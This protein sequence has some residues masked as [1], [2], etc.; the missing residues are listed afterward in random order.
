M[1][2]L[3][4]LTSLAAAVAAVAAVAASAAPA[5][6]APGANLA[7]VKTYLLEHTTALEGF[8]KNFSVVANRYYAAA[9]KANFDYRALGTQPAVRKDLTRA[10]ALWVAGNPM[11]EQVEGVVAGTPS[12]SVYDVILDAGSSA[13]AIKARVA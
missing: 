13:S 7:P 5:V 9:R 3:V 11:Y 12:L 4:V 8:T 10:K 1:N 6:P 2:R